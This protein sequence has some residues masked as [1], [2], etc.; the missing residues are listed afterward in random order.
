MTITP[1]LLE[2]TEKAE[3]EIREMGFSGFRVRTVGSGARLETI[4]SQSKLLESRKDE[5]VE[6]LLKYYD[7]VAFAERSG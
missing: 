3:A 6:I 7:S 5:I 2:R 4:P 1:D